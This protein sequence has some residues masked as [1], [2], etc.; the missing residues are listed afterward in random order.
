MTYIKNPY[1][2][3]FHKYKKSYF[4]IVCNGEFLGQE[5]KRHNDASC[6]SNKY[7]MR[8]D[9]QDLKL[10]QLLNIVQQ[11]LT[12]EDI[13]MNNVKNII[14]RDFDLDVIKKMRD[15]YIRSP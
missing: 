9:K 7:D 12:V 5:V 14:K 13:D 11:I 2:K 8:I 1:D 15:K 6:L 3:I 4:C 10:D